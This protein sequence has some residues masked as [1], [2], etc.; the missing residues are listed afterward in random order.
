V[1]ARGRRGSVGRRH[2]Q[3]VAP[4]STRWR[5]RWRGS[6]PRKRQ[7]AAAR[8]CPLHR[9]WRLSCECGSEIVAEKDVLSTGSVPKSLPSPGEWLTEIP[10][11]KA[12]DAGAVGSL[13]SPGDVVAVAVRELPFGHLG[14]AGPRA[15]PRRFGHRQRAPERSGVRLVVPSR[16]L[17]R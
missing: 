2:E 8:W 13:L 6:S 17:D 12:M 3:P 7:K 16:R 5:Q 1:L 10:L 14:L 15:P 4:R 11:D 9:G